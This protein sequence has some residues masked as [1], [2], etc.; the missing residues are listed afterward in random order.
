M[1]VAPH[2]HRPGHEHADLTDFLVFCRAT[3]LA[4]GE[5]VLASVT[6]GVAHID[7]LA[8]L[9]KMRRAGECW[10]Y[11]EC[12][13][14]DTAVAALG[15]AA[16]FTFAGR[17]RF[18]EAE[19]AIRRC[20]DSA[21]VAGDHARAFGGPR[22]F[23]TAAFDEAAPL[24]VVIPLRMVA[25]M[26]GE[27]T[28]V[29][30]LIVGA[31]TDPAAEAARMLGAH[32]RFA[33]FDYGP[34]DDAPA[35]AEATPGFTDGEPAY[36][37]RVRRILR[38]IHAGAY[39]KVVPAR[40]EQWNRAAGFDT[41]AALERLR[42][43]HPGAHTFSFSVDDAE[44]LGATPETLLRVTA[45]RLH[46]EAL[47]GTGPRARHA[48]EDARLEAALLADDKV[49]REQR[50]VTDTLARQLGE[51]GLTPQFSDTPRTLRLAHTRHLLTPL[52]ADLPPHIG[53]L[54]VAGVLHP[55]PAVAGTPRDA[56]LAALR[57]TDEPER[58]HYAG[59]SGWVDSRGDAHLVVNLR[60]ARVRPDGATLFAG[61][62]VVAGSDPGEEARETSL[63][64]RTV[65]DALAGD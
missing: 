43:K 12:P 39:T 25:R 8:V 16:R 65:A 14:E 35:A 49:R 63:K 4:R 27:H 53:A 1:I 22:A 51:L 18:R 44:W 47:A 45:G 3:A 36:V 6:L 60:C 23:I 46:T 31:D 58:G 11:R 55:T 26:A 64:L 33:A 42:E 37:E 19:A 56:A 28:A 52:S 2:R 40:A 15:V 9:L 48:A 5:P 50:L 57:D 32:A 20:F 21:C 38:G 41:A 34:D 13:A 10:H 30:N 24:D 17:D 59:A 7:P 61:A 29:A 62:G 54:T